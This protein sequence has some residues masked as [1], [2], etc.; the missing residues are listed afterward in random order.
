MGA[1]AATGVVPT[2]ALTFAARIPPIMAGGRSSRVPAGYVY[3][4]T[5]STMTGGV[6]RHSREICRG[7]TS[8]F[9][10]SSVQNRALL[11]PVKGARLIAD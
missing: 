2:S 1:L 5:C 3:G 9:L 11:A 4:D 7:F 8:H 10:G 6:S